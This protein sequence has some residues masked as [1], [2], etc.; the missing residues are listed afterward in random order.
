MIKVKK[1]LEGESVDKAESIVDL[2]KQ[3]E[4]K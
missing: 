1:E 3:I 4:Q 2:A